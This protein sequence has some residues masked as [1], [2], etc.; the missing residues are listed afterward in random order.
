[1]V[2]GSIRDLYET[3]GGPSSFLGFPLTDESPTFVQ[4][5]RFNR[6]QGGSIYWSPA[7]GTFEVHGAIR[8]AWGSLGWEFGFV[9][10]PTSHETATNV[11]GGR[12]NTFQ[13]ADI[14][15]SPASGAHEV[16]GAISGLWG[17]MGGPSSVLGYPTTDET[18]TLFDTGRYNHFQVGSIY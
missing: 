8:D 4:P 1:E 16:H 18:P 9:G 5:G 2:H 15:W 10:F 13:G 3:A 11:A 7:S 14:F 17:F 6:F 12:F